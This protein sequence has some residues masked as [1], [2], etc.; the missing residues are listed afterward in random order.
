[1]SDAKHLA[2]VVTLYES[3]SRDLV[4][5]MRNMA[6]QIE[7]GE[8]GDVRDAAFVIYRTGEEGSGIDVFGWGVDQDAA[9]THLLLSAGALRLAK[10]VETSA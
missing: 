5:K 9:T 4:A 3:N 10:A 1:M 2:E 6:D 8:W 7:A